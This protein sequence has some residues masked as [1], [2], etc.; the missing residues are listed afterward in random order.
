MKNEKNKSG[1]QRKGRWNH[2]GKSIVEALWYTGTQEQSERLLKWLDT[3]RREE[4]T[5]AKLAAY[6]YTVFVSSINM[7]L[8]FMCGK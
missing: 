2:E 1:L 5:A 8:D 6:E 3:G 4:E 7:F